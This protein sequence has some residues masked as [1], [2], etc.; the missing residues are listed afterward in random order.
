MK[1]NIRDYKCITGIGFGLAQTQVLWK[2]LKILKN[3]R[4]FMF[5]FLLK[6]KLNMKMKKK[7]IVSTLNL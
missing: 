3:Y 5:S 1:E 7:K 6:K 4:A 2:N